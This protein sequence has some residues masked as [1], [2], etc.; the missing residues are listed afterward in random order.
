[1]WSEQRV[2]FSCI[3]WLD[4]WRAIIWCVEWPSVEDENFLIDFSLL[5]IWHPF[6]VLSVSGDEKA[7]FLVGDDPIFIGYGASG[8]RL[9]LLE[10]ITLN[11]TIDQV[12][13]KRQQAGKPTFQT[14]GRS[15]GSCPKMRP[16]GAKTPQKRPKTALKRRFTAAAAIAQQRRKK[17]RDRI[18]SFH[19][20]IDKARLDAVHGNLHCVLVR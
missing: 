11:P 20:H 3:A 12:F 5:E 8:I 4:S 14:P 7:I 15:T 9:G 18:S 17:P 13:T 16:K 2:G 19:A 6:R 1:V 10:R